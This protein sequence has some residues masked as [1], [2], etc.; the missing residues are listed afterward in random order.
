MKDIGALLTSEGERWR[1]AQAP[2]PEASQFV[3]ALSAPRPRRRAG[4]MMVVALTAVA[5]VAV[6]ARVLDSMPAGGTTGASQPSL[7]SVHVASGPPAG[8]AASQSG[9]ATARRLVNFDNPISGRE[10]AADA[11]SASGLAFRPLSPKGLGSPKGVFVTDAPADQAAHRAIALVYDT[12]AFGVVD[13]VQA[14]PELPPGKWE[15]DKRNRVNAPAGTDRHGR[16]KIVSVRGGK[17]AVVSF[18]DDGSLIL[19]MWLENGVETVVRGP[20]LTEAQ[21]LQLV[22][23]L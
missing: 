14:L 6:V 21:A 13:V 10:V 7:A 20:T 11:I 22:E 3:A 8:A 2:A 15:A 17:D 18:E 5:A 1:E 23:A 16:A 9:G 12:T 19:V 4:R